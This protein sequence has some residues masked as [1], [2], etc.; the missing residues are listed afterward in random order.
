MEFTSWSLPYA[1][2]AQMNKSPQLQ[3]QCSSQGLTLCLSITLLV[4][5]I[6]LANIASVLIFMVP[7]NNFPHPEGITTRDLLRN[8]LQRT[9]N[10][11]RS[12]V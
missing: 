4:D 7:P 1:L 10:L 9:R 6:P 5:S 2:C 11:S 8:V 3:A 12:N